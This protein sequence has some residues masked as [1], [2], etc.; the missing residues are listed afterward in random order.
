MLAIIQFDLREKLSSVSTY[1][2]FL[3]F[4]ILS[5]LA[6]AAF[7]GLLPEGFAS[8]DEQSVNSPSRLFEMVSIITFF[9]TLIM[10]ATMGRAIQQDAEHNIWHFFY[11]SPI[12]KWQY[13]GGRYLAAFITLA[14]IF[15]S[16][17]LGSYFGSQLP[18][19][20]KSLV[21]DVG[22]Y[23]Y[24]SPYLIVVLPNIFF[25]GAIFFSIGTLSR[26]MLPV[27]IASVLL[28]ML[29]LVASSLARGEEARAIGALIDPFAQKTLSAITRHWN[30]TERNSQL[31]PLEGVL[32]YNRALW[33]GIG[34]VALLLCYWRF[35]FSAV[36]AVGKQKKSAAAAATQAPSHVRVPQISPNFTNSNLFSIFFSQC[37]LN[38]LETVKNVYFIVIALAGVLF[39]FH[40]SGA[41]GIMTDTPTYPATYE[42]LDFLGGIFG[43]FIVVITTL[44]AGELVWRERDARIAQLLDVLPVP[45]WL[46]LLSKLVALISLQ[47]I[48]LLVFMLCGI[49]IQTMKGYT[50]YEIGQYLQFLFVFQWSYYALLAALAIALQVILNN[51]Y[52]AY[53]AMIAYSVLAMVLPGIGIDHPM[54]MYAGGAQPFYS[55][56]NGYGHNVTQ[57]FWY[58]LFWSG[59]AI[60]LIALSMLLWGRGVTDSWRARLRQAKYSLTPAIKLSLVS[61][62][63]IFFGVG[64]LLF[65]FNNVLHAYQS[66]FEQ[67]SLAASYEKKYKQYEM[68]PQPRIIGVKV[69]ADIYPKTR[70][71]KIKASY[72]LNNDSGAVIDEVFVSIPTDMQVLGMQ[73]DR[74]TTPNIQD[75]LGFY[76]FKLGQSLAVG[77]QLKFD[78]E[79]AIIPKQLAGMGSDSEVRAN[80]SF[81][82]NKNSMPRI[83]YAPAFE[84]TSLTTR[85]N[86]GLGDRSAMMER[87]DPRGLSY[88]YNSKDAQFVSF[89]ATVST[90]IGQ[91]AI[92]PGS[93]QKEWTENGRRYFHYKADQAILNFYAFLSADYQVKKAQ[94]QDVVIEI[95]Y[96]KG[97]EY[98]LDRMIQGVQKS[99][100]YYSKNFSPYQFKSLRIVEFPRYQKFAEPFPGMIAYS[101][102]SGFIAKVDDKDSN[103]IDNPFFL[104]ASK[105]AHQWWL[106]QIIAGDTKG[107]T[108]LAY[109]LANYSAL[110][111]MEETYGKEKIRILLQRNLENYLSG[112]GKEREKESALA[113]N[114]YQ[115]YVQSA[116]GGMAMYL[117]Q[118]QIGADKVNLA[119]RNLIAQYAHKGAPYPSSQSLVD[120]L[121]A[122]AS[123][124]KQ[125]LI[126]DLFEA[127][128]LFDNRAVKSEA[129]LLANGEYE[130]T[131]DVAANKLKADEHG[132][133]K[134]VALH[135][136]IDI[137][138]DD[139]DGSPLLRERKL[140]DRKEM[141]F[142]M[143]VKGIP[144]KAGIDPDRKYIDRKP[145][146]NLVKVS[147]RGS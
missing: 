134:E 132:V 25:L 83:G 22:L 138:I 102:G 98:N 122:V 140:I 117:L 127:I 64:S 109:T 24:F 91:I 89:D 85:K 126:T 26:K 95:D 39:M 35:N 44:Y 121:R 14:L 135:D 92:A 141:R 2:Y 100:G 21:G 45:N 63:F 3:L 56:M 99:L 30:M 75:K 84:L 106:H 12:T 27:Y 67:D 51:K 130:V 16:A 143:R 20:P 13:L 57:I 69:A 1:V 31:V 42:L 123:E 71:A 48:L 82:Q 139:K 137:G 23:A 5:L 81:F 61:G 53:F 47:G 19:I 28:L 33:I 146:D 32:V 105:V 104:T 34:I 116:K 40:T 147:L 70:S 6:M 7:G 76:S 112:R 29:Y 73:F 10:A 119:L 59:A 145:E 55:D 68:R 46:P 49:L 54:L 90:D 62:S 37:R 50:H 108:S 43:F 136:S 103:A 107:A 120:A 129:K 78:F 65:Y 128:I 79:L 60:V 94:W 114:E 41:L 125:A 72:A 17:V 131:L 88:P 93:L 66:S 9:G 142:T 4:F 124:D 38:L 111:V 15:F 113:I 97:H 133:E 80:G 86:L 115:N 118:D 8:F 74:A 36:S 96:H 101:E 18:G 58:K 144:A 110:M 87:D 52:L 11:S 77:A